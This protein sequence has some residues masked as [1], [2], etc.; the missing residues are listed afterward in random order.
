MV[1]RFPMKSLGKMGSRSLC[2][3][4]TSLLE[5]RFHYSEQ[6]GDAPLLTMAGCSARFLNYYYRLFFFPLCGLTC[7]CTNK[8]SR[9]TPALKATTSLIS[10]AHR[11]PPHRCLHKS[12]TV[13]SSRALCQHWRIDLRASRAPTCAWQFRRLSKIHAAKR[14]AFLSAYIT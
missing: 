12:P 2:Q 13:S 6:E 11:A 1:A 8:A 4:K 5:S 14:L 7:A 10:S 9:K 3:K